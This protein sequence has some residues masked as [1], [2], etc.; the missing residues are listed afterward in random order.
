MSCDGRLFKG[1][2]LGLLSFGGAGIRWCET[3]CGHGLDVGDFV[4]VAVGFVR[5]TQLGLGLCC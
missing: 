4:G 1:A 2:R 5:M 3:V